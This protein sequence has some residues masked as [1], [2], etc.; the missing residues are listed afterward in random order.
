MWCGVHVCF[1]CV[2]FRVL[3]CLFLCKILDRLSTVTVDCNQIIKG[4]IGGHNCV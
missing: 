3:C 2:V 1:V 4:D